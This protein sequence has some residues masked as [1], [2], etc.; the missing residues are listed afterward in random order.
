LT[1]SEVERLM[2]QYFRGELSSAERDEFIQAVLEDQ[3]LYNAFAEEE[4][5]KQLMSDPEIR[6]RIDTATLPAVGSGRKLLQILAPVSPKWRLAMAALVLLLIIFPV[7][8][9]NRFGGSPPLSVR[10]ISL[11]LMP[12]ER[13]SSSG[14]ILRLPPQNHVIVLTVRV[15]GEWQGTYS[16][17]LDGPRRRE[18][19]WKGLRPEPGLNGIQNVTLR[20]LS[21]LLTPGNYTLT[22]YKSDDG[23]PS[24]PVANYVFSVVP[25]GP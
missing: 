22:L 11:L 1:Q 15:N 24:N 19:A 18:M 8:L 9:I 20:F 21:N 12:A 25:D 14:A 7:I 2:P 23:S 6:A 5:L 10:S 13:G 16:A 3:D 4:I 17:V